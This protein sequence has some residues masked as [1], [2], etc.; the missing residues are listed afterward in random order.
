MALTEWVKAFFCIDHY[1]AQRLSRPQQWPVVLDILFHDPNFLQ[2]VG[3][4]AP[5]WAD[6]AFLASLSRFANLCTW[7]DTLQRSY[8][9]IVESKAFDAA[10]YLARY[11]DVGAVGVDPIKHY[12][13][14]G[15]SEA[16]DPS[17]DFSTLFYF[18]ENRDVVVSGTNPLVHYISEGRKQGR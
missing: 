6:K 1:A 14:S 8:D 2:F 5:Q 10:Y 9:T 7:P 11:P 4:S 18:R 12:L 3:Q 13:T 15:A 16:R 17:A